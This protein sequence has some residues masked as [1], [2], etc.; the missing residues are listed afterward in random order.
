[1]IQNPTGRY[2]LVNVE[3]PNFTT[4]ITAT[5]ISIV[6]PSVFIDLDPRSH[7]VDVESNETPAVA[8]ASSLICGWPRVRN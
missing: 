3:R 1:M 8:V 5:I 7:K 6:I 4:R 2:I